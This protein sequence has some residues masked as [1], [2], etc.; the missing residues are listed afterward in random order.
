MREP[1]GAAHVVA[2]ERHGLNKEVRV[3][4]GL[5]STRKHDQGV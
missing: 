1:E 4:A 3:F 2:L 5:A